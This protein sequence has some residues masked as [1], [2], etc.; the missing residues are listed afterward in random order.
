MFEQ[1]PFLNRRRLTRRLFLVVDRLCYDLL[2]T[3]RIEILTFLAIRNTSAKARVRTEINYALYFNIAAT[4]VIGLVGAAA[5]IAN[6][7]ALMDG[8]HSAVEPI[9]SMLGPVG[10]LLWQL[11]C[12]TV[13]VQSAAGIAIFATV[14][15]LHMCKVNSCIRALDR[16]KTDIPHAIDRVLDI[17]VSLAHFGY[18]S[19]E[20]VNVIFVCHFLKFFLSSMI[21]ATAASFLGNA[22]FVVLVQS[23]VHPGSICLYFLSSAGMLNQQALYLTKVCV[24]FYL[25]HVNDQNNKNLKDFLEFTKA[26]DF[27]MRFN[28]IRVELADAWKLV[29]V[30]SR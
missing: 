14:A 28:G 20:W 22:P 17:D 16:V 29:A 5:D 11:T 18:K 19:A 1:F 6:I 23:I 15:N 8:S 3:R 4:L 7:S 9:R 12:I 27:C 26:G 21:R 2:T 25:K 30:A 10:I 13:N 24:R